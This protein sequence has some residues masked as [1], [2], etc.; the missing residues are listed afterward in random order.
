[1]KNPLLMREFI[2]K[3]IIELARV[4]DIFYVI[5]NTSALKALTWAMSA[6]LQESNSPQSAILSPF[7]KPQND[8][9]K[10]RLGGYTEAALL[11][12]MAQIQQLSQ[13]INGL[14]QKIDNMIVSGAPVPIIQQPEIQNRQSERQSLLKDQ[15]NRQ[16]Q[17]QDPDCCI[18]S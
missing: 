8:S 13:M 3:I 16:Q 6:H 15:K 7:T 18:I 12:T 17:S 4:Q 11:A 2:G 14:S 10:R 5:E 9:G 1:M